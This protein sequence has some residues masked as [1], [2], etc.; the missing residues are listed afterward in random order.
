M[1]REA[2]VLRQVPC[3]TFQYILRVSLRTLC[4]SPRVDGHLREHRLR[5]ALGARDQPR[6]RA[7]LG[8]RIVGDGMLFAR[9]AVAI[10]IAVVAYIDVS[11]LRVVAVCVQIPAMLRQRQLLLK[12]RQPLD[13]RVLLLLQALEERLVGD[14]HRVDGLAEEE[15][16]VLTPG[17]ALREQLV[18]SLAQQLDCRA[19]KKD[20][21]IAHVAVPQPCGSV[22]RQHGHKES[23]Q[24]GQK[25]VQRLDAQRLEE[26]VQ[27]GQ[28]LL[29][30]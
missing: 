30:N 17:R 15:K 3:R 18:C 13:D 26:R 19:P 8:E 1:S 21:T 2:P 27:H 24:P 14:K 12:K 9:V 28:L 22:N 6:Q 7:L 5:A 25:V 16:H 4:T 10:A 11:A 29:E 23:L 20:L